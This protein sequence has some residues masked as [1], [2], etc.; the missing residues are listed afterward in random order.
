MSYISFACKKVSIESIIRCG[1][2]L[3]KTEYKAL[4]YLLNK[5]EEDIISISKN[6]KKDRTTAQRCIKKLLSQGLI[7]RRQVNLEEGGFLFYYQVKD[8]DEIKK[9]VYNN[10][11]NWRDLVEKE[12]KNW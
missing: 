11:C 4:K 2:G 5:D 1:F 3:N 9:N 8:K 12:L 10:F 6:I 7:S